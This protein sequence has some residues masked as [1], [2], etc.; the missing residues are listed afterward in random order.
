MSDWYRI[1]TRSAVCAV[2]VV[3]D[4]CITCCPY[5]H[6][7]A[8]GKTFSKLIQHLEKVGS[9]VSVTKCGEKKG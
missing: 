6:H 5:L 4:R 3:N 7:L 9:L 2:K 8:T 1:E